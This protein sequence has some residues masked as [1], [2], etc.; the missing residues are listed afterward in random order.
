MDA[1]FPFWLVT[2]PTWIA[3]ILMFTVYKQDFLRSGDVGDEEEE[4]RDP[5]LKKRLVTHDG[6]D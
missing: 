3:T 2:I 1:A 5:Y 4:D 6:D